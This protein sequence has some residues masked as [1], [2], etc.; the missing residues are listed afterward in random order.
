MIWRSV[1]MNRKI[2][3]LL[4]LLIC[5]TI[6]FVGCGR[7][8]L[9]NEN[10]EI[11]KE[12]SEVIKEE[13]ESSFEDNKPRLNIIEIMDSE[14]AEF[15]SYNYQDKSM[16]IA[17]L[18]VFDEFGTKNEGGA[19]INTDENTLSFGIT[20]ATGTVTGALDGPNVT[21][22]MDLATNKI[23]DKKFNPAPNYAELGITEFIHYSEVVIELSEERLIEI[24]LFFKKLI[25]E[26]EAQE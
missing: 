23:V 9:I 24:G 6:L 7:N 8:N 11:L 3:L 26:I 13:V 19:S 15:Y 17:G 10:P 21:F 18:K 1:L 20:K 16:Y 5:A 2:V 22:K 12:D 14:V 4:V 25:N